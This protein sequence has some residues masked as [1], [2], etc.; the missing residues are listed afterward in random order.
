VTSSCSLST[1]SISSVVGVLLMATSCSLSIK[2]MSSMVGVLLMTSS[3]S[4]A[5]KSISSMV[6]VSFIALLVLF[7]LCIFQQWQEFR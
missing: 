4:L 3:C 7:L 6:G 2:S 1:K 5:I